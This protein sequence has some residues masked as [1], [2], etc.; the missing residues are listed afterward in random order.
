LGVDLLCVP[1]EYNEK[2]PAAVTAW[3]SLSA[4]PVSLAHGREGTLAP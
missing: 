4:T 3:V 2:T 1:H